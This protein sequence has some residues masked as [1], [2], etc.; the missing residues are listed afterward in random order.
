M[1]CESL[2][3]SVASS[4]QLFEWTPNGMGGGGYVW[5]IYEGTSHIDWLQLVG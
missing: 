1:L 4:G 5:T 3:L 2:G